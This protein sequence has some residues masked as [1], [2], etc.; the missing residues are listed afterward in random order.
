MPAFPREELEAMVEKWLDERKSLRDTEGYRVDAS[1][2][3]SR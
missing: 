3:V 2:N 1:G